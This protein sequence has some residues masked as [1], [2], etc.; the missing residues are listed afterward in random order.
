MISPRYAQ[1][2]S[3]VLARAEAFGPP[4]DPSP[5]ARASAI[6]QIAHAIRVGARVRRA[7]RVAMGMAAIAAVFA[8]SFGVARYTA[9]LSPS[10]LARDEAAPV[11]DT[12]IVAR[13]VEPGAAIFVSRAMGAQAPLANDA[14]IAAGS[15]LVTPAGVSAMLSFSTGTSV[16]LAKSSDLTVVGEGETQVLRLDAGSVDLHVAKLH[17]HERFLVD[18]VDAEV[19]VRGTRFRVS[20]VPSEP[21][22]GGGAVTRVAVVEGVVVV[23]HAGVESR[24]AAGEEWPSGCVAPSRPAPLRFTPARRGP[25]M[26]GA[27]SSSLRAENALFAEAV[28]AKHRK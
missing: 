18:T 28:A 9:R 27:Q 22:C 26:E 5:E 25:L 12:R 3:R 24:V 17:G 19:E 10:S 14:V 13:P 16:M 20:L 4:P 23:R 1:M 7:R 8:V 2:A 6:T 15:R 21:S 11:V